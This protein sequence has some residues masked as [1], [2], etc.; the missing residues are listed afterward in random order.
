MTL[1]VYGPEEPLLL[2]IQWACLI[3]FVIT[4]IAVPVMLRNRPDLSYYVLSRSNFTAPPTIEH[5][6]EIKS[7]TLLILFLLPSTLEHL[8]AIALSNIYKDYVAA[9]GW[10]RWISYIFS[11]P[12]LIALVIYSIGPGSELAVTISTVGLIVVCI[13]MGPIVEH[14]TIQRNGFLFIMGMFSGFMA[15]LF[16]FIPVWYYYSR[17]DIPADMEPYISAMVSIITALYWS[18]G[19]VP[20]YVYLQKISPGTPYYKRE[21]IYCTLSLCAK[22]PLAWLYASMLATRD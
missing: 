17:A 5:H 4:I 13:C 8:F 21:I 10:H 2:K 9:I 16:A 3:C 14:A 11:A 1:R 22:L 18:F 19:F 6:S 7:Y 20:I 12:S 15:L